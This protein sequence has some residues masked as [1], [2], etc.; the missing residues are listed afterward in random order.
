MSNERKK[1]VNLMMILAGVPIYLLVLF[2]I[3]NTFFNTIRKPKEN[4]QNE[5]QTVEVEYDNIDVIEEDETEVTIIEKEPI[6]NIDNHSE[7]SSPETTPQDIMKDSAPQ[8]TD[9]YEVL[10]N[11]IKVNQIQVGVGTEQIEYR[12]FALED[13]NNDIV[14]TARA[15][16]EYGMS[17]SN[18]F[19]IRPITLTSGGELLGYKVEIKD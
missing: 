17:G 7:S 5:I 19:M 12:E 9:N 1:R 3:I 8:Y 18:K 14:L 6:E 13:Y 2:L 10:T 15:A 11:D 4:E 16:L